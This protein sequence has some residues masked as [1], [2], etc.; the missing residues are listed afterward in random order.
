MKKLRL[1]LPVLLVAALCFIFPAAATE[2]VEAMTV[3]VDQTNGLDTN[4]GLTEA[5]AVQTID[6]AYVLLDGK[7]A[8]N[9][10]GTIV[11]VSNYTH[12][13]AA[14]KENIAPSVTSHSY[15]VV[16]KGKTA[17]VEFV[18]NNTKQSYLQ[19]PGPT[20]IKQLCTY[21]TGSS[22]LVSIHG[23]G[24]N[25]K[26][27]IG[28]GV[29]GG[30]A[31]KYVTLAAIPYA[32]TDLEEDED[33]EIYLEVN[34]GTWRNV[35][36]TS[37]SNACRGN[38][39]LVINGGTFTNVATRYSR[40]FTGDVR[41]ELNGGTITTL[42]PVG[43]YESTAAVKGDITIVRAGATIG[44]TS[45][46]GTH[47][48]TLTE[49]TVETESTSLL[50]LT[51]DS[52][53]YKVTLYSGLSGTTKIPA[54]R[55][56]TVDGVTKYYYENL[57]AGAYRTTVSRDGYYTVKKA[58]YFTEEQLAA[59]FEKD[60]S[61]QQQV[62]LSDG[63][64][65]EYQP[66]TYQEY[67]DG[68]LALLNDKENAPWYINYAQYLNTPIFAD[69]KKHQQT[70][71]EEL[72]AYIQN[73]DSADDHMYVYSIGK[74]T[75]GKNIPVVIFSLTDLSGAQTLEDAAAL[76]RANGKLTVHYQG[77]TH[78]NEP[79]GGEAALATIGRLDTADY[80][81]R[82]LEKMDIYV[83]PRINP[84]GTEN[85]VRIVYGSNPTDD[86][87]V[88]GWNP[89][90]DMLMARTVEVQAHHYAYNL[91]MPELAI[92]SHEFTID[93]SADNKVY[94]DMLVAGGYNGNSGEEFTTFTED[95]ALMIKDDIVEQGM[96]F[97]F[98]TTVSN[99]DYSVSG[100]IY[101]GLRGS[102]SLLLESR[103][104]GFG[105]H[106]MDRRV[107][108][109][110]VAVDT[111]LN[112]AYENT[113]TVIEASNQERQRI[114]TNGL[115]YEAED[116][117][118]VAHKKVADP[119]LAHVTNKYD[120][121]TGAV[122]GTA[123]MATKKYVAD[124]TRVR[125]TAYV[126]PAGQEWTP[127]VLELLE[128]HAISYEY[129]AP[130]TAINLQQYY[131]TIDNENVTAETT[132][133]YEKV[134][135]FEQGAYVM[136]MNQ[137]SG[138]ILTSL[139]EPDLKNE[140]FRETDTG[141]VN[142]YGNFAQL[143]IIPNDG[144]SFPIY[145]Y[146]RDLNA[147]GKIDTTDASESQVE[148]KVYVHSANGHDTDDAYSEITPAKTIEYAFA[149]LDALMENAPEGTA[150]TVVFLDLYELGEEAYTFPSHDY[151][152]VLTSKTGAEGF[153]KLYKSGSAWIAFSGD[154]TLENMTVWPSG[155]NDYYYILA[156]GHDLT[157]KETVITKPSAVDTYFTIAAGGYGGSG[158]LEGS[159]TL[160]ILGG[161]WK[162]VYGSSYTG[163]MTGDTQIVIENA[164][165]LR[166]SASY[167]AKHTGHI[168]VSMKNTQVRE[169]IIYMANYNKNDITG[170][171]LTLGEGVQV[172]TVYTGS[173]QAGNISGDAT[174]IVDG[175]DM[176]NI[177]LVCGA[178]NET[179]TVGKNILAYK[180]GLIGTISS[181]QYDEVQVYADGQFHKV[182]VKLT[183]LSLDTA[184]VAFGYK[185]EFALPAQIQSMMLSQGYCLWL[186]EDRVLDRSV[187]AYESDL[188][189][190]LKNIDVDNYGEAKINAKVYL[191]LTNG[192][193]IETDA[194]S[195]SMR[196]M[197]ELIDGMDTLSAEKIQA[198]KAMLAKFTAPEQWD[199]PNLKAA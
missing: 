54:T 13:F 50:V 121:M 176:T 24:V 157:V 123:T 102:V 169:G 16:L 45:S 14:A 124:V 133:S 183:M 33:K 158:T 140:Y 32:A 67:T 194:V 18:L 40:A 69:G 22:S 68:M 180:S 4:D 87:P 2:T 57:A 103:G 55:T 62:L 118:V 71:Q 195:Y 91:F 198:V 119:R 12:S 174:V 113:E 17:D 10:T 130:G 38:A 175:A 96:D 93:Y 84:D 34:S 51:V 20:T 131:G 15:M 64:P 120:Y 151:P 168:S 46:V 82:L 5:T 186:T 100:T 187:A 23:A 166:Y 49:E 76:I 104:I 86:N 31:G 89:N 161:T 101:A 70:T 85:Y 81:D 143:G 134:V 141:C 109:H 138:L 88:G 116:R 42:Y 25:G 11:L 78:G 177:Q 127:A 148:Y 90:R 8:D 35:Y 164:S 152:V 193:V 167:S 179:G 128:R 75:A 94:S 37:Y 47:T 74:S 95:I 9:G 125:P 60:V 159:N 65:A 153:S 146:I 41:M 155:K 147:Q 188:T 192:L 142:T 110:L 58:R 56:E 111:I 132:L 181:D 1:L 26:L 122:S 115:T 171:T 112:Y 108:A 172:N 79:A 6:A 27:I 191:K 154:V 98:Y 185:A 105:N 145:R 114:I 29:T 80:G 173:C 59:G 36:A 182:S 196:D 150:G 165:I 184:H 129:Y 156:N 136:T 126:I 73:L 170:T 92:D 19:L 63:T 77:L 21:I 53:E 178:S 189:L 44:A 197:V 48:G 39:T 139:M 162:N 7:L 52:S 199:I 28:E 107:I 66:T 135:V 3:Y 97:N 149:Q 72:E 83:I 160:T 163:S 99:N 144:E 117:L 43:M 137:S 190:R 61:T 106:T 30:S